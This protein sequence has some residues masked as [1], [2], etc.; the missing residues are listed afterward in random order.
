[1]SIL[2]KIFGSSSTDHK[3]ETAIANDA[4]LVDVRTPGEFASGTVSG[5]INIPYDEVTRNLRQF[6]GKPA[7]VVFCRSGARSAQAKSMLD[8]N[9]VKNV[10]NGGT[11]QHV[12]AIV[13]KLNNK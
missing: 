9:R 10:I 8:R 11:W 4:L 5:A 6:E 12:A 13:E 7:V 2:S 1:M 3:L